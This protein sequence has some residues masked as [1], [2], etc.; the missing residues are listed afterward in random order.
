MSQEKA[1][2]NKNIKTHHIHGTRNVWER[3]LK[4]KDRWQKAP[5][6][7]LSFTYITHKESNERRH[8][9]YIA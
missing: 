8:I 9:F 2:N 6:L 7:P 4:E 1:K 5:S 3:K